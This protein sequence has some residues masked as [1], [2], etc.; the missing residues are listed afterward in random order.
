MHTRVEFDFHTEATPEQVVGLLTDF[1]PERPD[2]WPALSSKWFEVYSVG[3]HEADVREGQDRPKIWAREHYEWSTPGKVTWTVVEC[4]AMAPGSYVSL[5]AKP[6]A[7]GGSDVHGEW[8]RTSRN[9]KGVMAV[10]AMRAMGRRILP[11]YFKKVYDGLA[12]RT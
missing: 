12:T 4:P 7:D 10:V 1:S 2:H 5:A 8:D 6:A 3:E 9:A 11:R